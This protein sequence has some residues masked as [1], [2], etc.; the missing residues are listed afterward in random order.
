[1]NILYFLIP[2]A[3]ALASFFLFAFLW[4][5]KNGQFDDLV[6]PAHRI[7][8]DDYK[9][10]EIENQPNTSDSHKVTATKENFGG[11]NV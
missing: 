5:A 1:M 7:F 3:L 8:L 4:A 9:K 10:S 2:A 6:T 11:E